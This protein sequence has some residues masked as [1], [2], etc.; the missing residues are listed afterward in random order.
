MEA[1]VVGDLGRIPGLDERLEP[2]SDELGRAAAEDGLLA[3]QIGLG[4]LLERRLEDAGATGADPDGVGECELTGVARGVLLDR[5]QRRGAVALGEEASNDMAGAFG[6]DHDHVVVGG[7]RDPLVED[8]EAV[9]EQH[10]RPRRE[11]RLDVLV[12]TCGCT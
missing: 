4:L 2:G 7:G 5:D 8:V 1:L 10:G 6:G 3:E 11:V 9:G 12:K